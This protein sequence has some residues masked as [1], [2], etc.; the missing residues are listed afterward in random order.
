MFKKF[1]IDVD[2]KLLKKGAGGKTEKGATKSKTGGLNIDSAVLIE[3]LD[4]LVPR[5]LRIG[6][7]KPIDSSGFS[8]DG[9][10]FIAYHEYCRDIDKI[11]GG[12]IPYELI[13]GAFFVINA[14]NKNALADALN[15]VL[16]VKKLDHFSEEGGKFSIPSFIIANNNKEYPLHAL[17][18]DIMN[19]YI[20]KN[21]AVESEFEIMMVYNEGLLIKDWEKGGHRYIGLE[22]G[23]DTLMWFFIIMNEYLD[24]ER[25]DVFDA[26]K[27]VR[28]EKVY[29]EF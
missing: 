1:F 3:K 24:V 26:R 20:S 21:T 15:R 25:E 7:L 11:L 12:Y 6:P 29:N 27:Y 23:D 17:K 28:S 2:K 8:P 13:Q 5:K 9:V 14:L 22:T 16:T 19:F 18:N 4:G 10:D